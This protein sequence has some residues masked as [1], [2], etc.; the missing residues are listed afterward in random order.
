[1]TTDQQATRIAELEREVAQ[2]KEQSAAARRELESLS[3]A[4]SH[5]LRAPLRSLSGFSQVLL[6]QSAGQ[7][8]AQASHYLA[9][10]QQAGAKV[11]ELIDAL[12]GLSRI[13]R[14]DIHL[15]TLDFTQLCSEALT[16][17]QSKYSARVVDVAIE[18]G[19]TIVGDGRL[20][21]NAMELLLDNAF[22]FTSQQPAARIAIGTRT[23]EY[24][25]E[26]FI[27]DNGVG[28]DMSYADKLFRPFQRLHTEVQ[29]AGLGIGLA[30]V[31]RIIARHDG[32][33]WAQAQPNQGAKFIFCL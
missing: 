27:D 23:G 5:D 31:Q 10:I 25:L 11:S 24:G 7:L 33:I 28:F 4:I 22:K 14:A 6:E 32:R 29:F 2:L 8:D 26:Y 13:S 21:R 1:M 19:M 15:R 3:Y 17:I 12:L 30:S 18:P 20:L 16:T 9:R